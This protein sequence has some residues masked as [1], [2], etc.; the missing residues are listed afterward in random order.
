MFMNSDPRNFS[1]P[2]FKAAELMSIGLAVL[3]VFMLHPSF[4]SETGNI[5]LNQ[6]SKIYDSISQNL[7]TNI[8]PDVMKRASKLKPIDMT[9]TINGLE[10]WEIQVIDKLVQAAS[11]MDTAH[12][13]QSD[14]LGDTLYRELASSNNSLEH[15]AAFLVRVNHGRWDRFNNFEPFVGNESR[16]P[17][18]FVFPQNLTRQ[19]LDKYI[20]DHP[21]AKEALLSPYTV[22]RRDGDKLIAVPYHE[23][24]RK[25]VMPAADLLDQAANL[26]QNQS[27]K[28]Y[29]KLRAQALR[30]DDYY[31]ADLA[32]LDLNSSIDLDIGP[33]ESY[34]DN[35][36]GQK[37]FYQAD[38]MIVDQEASKTLGKFKQSI[39]DLQRN[40]PVA[41]EYKPNQTGT[42][43]A[44]EIV[45][46]VYRAGLPRAGY[47]TVAYSL[48]NDPKVWE[49][50][51]T[52]KVLMRNSIE[53]RRNVVLEPLGMAILDNQTAGYIDR[54]GYFDWLLMHEIAH[55]LGPRKVKS[56][57]QE[58]T[59][60]Q[61]LGEYYSPI[62]EGKA[63]IVGLYNLAYLRHMGIVSESLESQYT[64]Y[65]TE[66]LRSMRFGEGSAYGLIRS[67]AW[68]Y[69][70]ESG[71]LYLDSNSG[72]FHMDIDK[73]TPAIRDLAETLLTIEGMG[74]K[75]AAV[76]FLDHYAEADPKL[77]A[78]LEKANEEVPIEVVPLYPQWERTEPAARSGT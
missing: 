29:L 50:K 52:K 31:Q 39:P 2:V 1:F 45:Q 60:R 73:M 27:L 36:T 6:E 26:S 24:Y 63:D 64:G 23:V 33:I 5:I 56:G 4:A 78:L 38:V 17:G 37:A 58:Q 41:S 22:I 69:F 18:G 19:E 40:L 43:T 25:Y 74:D 28:T 10:E 12:W 72:R 55:T 66:A 47:I 7:S 54:D 15:A 53:T 76:E 51:G 70:M 9:V 42:M 57:G 71:A 16:P 34:D 46:S 3:L 11:F 49:A 13:Q 14:P 32:W 68:N 44:I 35:F 61:A 65:L 8:A 75:K 67:A 62:E 30:T 48:P 77:H 59:V 20:A 21:E